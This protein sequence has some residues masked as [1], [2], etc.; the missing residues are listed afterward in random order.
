MCVRAGNPVYCAPLGC[1]LRRRDKLSVHSASS[2]PAEERD[3]L[4]AFV[5][6]VIM[7][8]NLKGKY[9]RFAS[10]LFIDIF[11]ILCHIQIGT[12]ISLHH[13]FDALITRD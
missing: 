2:C 7:A 5:M 6:R 12:V 10:K 9:I 8:A 3:P 4:P 1:K 13:M 11:S